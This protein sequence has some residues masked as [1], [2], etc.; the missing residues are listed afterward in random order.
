[1][2]DAPS[3]EAAVLRALDRRGV[4]TLTLNRA[5]KG[6]RYNQAMLDT[7]LAE[8]TRLGADPA[9][10]VIVL[11]A[12][13]KHF[14]VGAEIGEEPQAAKDARATI[15]GLCLALDDVPKPTVALVHGACIGGGLALVSCCDIVIAARSAFFSLP[16]V[17][18]G[19]APGPLIPFFLRAIDQRSLRRYLL[20]GE[21]FA[22]EAAMRI[23]LVHELYDADGGDAALAALLDE[24]LLA[25]PNAVTTAK[26]LLRRLAQTPISNGLLAELQREF[27]A[28]RDSP[29]ALEGTASFREKRKPRWAAPE[30]EQ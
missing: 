18:L 5:E 14:C 13:G 12:G 4:A 15:P 16:E 30:N 2:T 20:S 3:P 8:V 21:R 28:R 24:L 29:E 23:G 19:F 6:N 22:A 11:R 25:G 26:G 17:R 10:R 9:V 27:D 1:V 7:L